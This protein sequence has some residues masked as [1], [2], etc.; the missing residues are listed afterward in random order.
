M[1]FYYFGGHIGS[2]LI[3]IL[4]ESHFSG[5][6]FTYD[7]RQGDFF[8]RLARDIKYTE[9]IKYMI[10]IRPYAISPQ[11]LCMINQSINEIMPNRLELN[12]ISGHI[13]DHEKDVGGILGNVNDSSSNIDRSEY[14]IE[15]INVLEEMKKDKKN[16]VP[17][18]YVSTSNK[19]VFEACR[20]LNVKMIIP[21]RNYKH[22][23]WILKSE[24]NTVIEKGEPFSLDG[25]TS[26]ISLGP[27]IRETQ[28][29]IDALEKPYVT[30][31]TEYYTYNEFVLFVKKLESEG[32]KQIMVNGWPQEERKYVIKFIKKYKEENK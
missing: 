26:L 3:S 5:V 23:C 2:N 15:Y 14:L 32:I 27:I 1:E 13:K 22:G 4:D 30:Y 18:Y 29:E 16:Q 20:S 21:H 8:T 6:L 24:Y 25:Q 28:E 17:E 12:L 10:A 19:F 31:D 9:K 11:Y 7:A